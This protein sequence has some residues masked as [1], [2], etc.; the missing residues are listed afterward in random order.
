MRLDLH[1][2][3]TPPKSGWTGRCGCRPC[4]ADRKAILR[5]SAQMLPR[6]DLRV[7][8]GGGAVAAP[9]GVLDE[10][11]IGDEDEVVFCEL[12]PPRFPSRIHS[13]RRAT[14]RRPAPH[15]YRASRLNSRRGPKPRF[16]G[17]GLSAPAPEDL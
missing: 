11:A 12:T 17:L 16:L 9:R 15:P 4:W 8:G 10:T 13:T 6:A 3:T 5:H 2:T 7:E 1:Q 14:L